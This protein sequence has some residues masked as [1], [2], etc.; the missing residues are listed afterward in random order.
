MRKLL[1]IWVFINSILFAQA[2]QNSD[3]QS[4]ILKYLSKIRTEAVQTNFTLKVIPKN[5]VTSQSVSGNLI[6]KGNLFFLTMDDVKVWYD[7]KT[8]W[9]YFE[10]SNE[11]TITQPTRDELAETNPMAVLSSYT[12]GSKA[13]FSKVKRPGFQV[14]DLVSRSKNDAVKKVTI[15]FTKNGE[16]LHSIQ[17]FN[18]DGSKNELSLT[19]YRTN[20]AVQSTTFTFNKAKYPGVVINDLR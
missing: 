8:Q 19:A 11:V 15:E 6:M 20:A 7:G 14:I 3:A 5:A 4:I 2:Q 10:E 16:Q 12:S 17:L 13:T 1:S 9:A 18:K